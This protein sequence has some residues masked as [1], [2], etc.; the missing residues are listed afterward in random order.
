MFSCHLPVNI[1]YWIVAHVARFIITLFYDYYLCIFPILGTYFWFYIFD[2]LEWVDKE[3][4]RR[5]NKTLGTEICENLKNLYINKIYL[6]T[7]YLKFKLWFSCHLPVNISYCILLPEA[8]FIT[9]LFYY[10]LSTDF[11][12]F[13]N[14]GD[15]F[16]I[17][18]LFKKVVGCL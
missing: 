11:N 3:R 8:R 12:K 1:S 9:I 5:K 4:R 13:P 18:Y 7:S 14:I 6:Q 15:M 2:D 16:L 17:L 10:Y